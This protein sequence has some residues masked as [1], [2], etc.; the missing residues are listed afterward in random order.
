MLSQ[1]VLFFIL[2][3]LSPSP[4]NQR[5]RIF[6]TFA[7]IKHITKKAVFPLFR[8]HCF[9][10]CRLFLW[11]FYFFAAVVI[12]LFRGLAARQIRNASV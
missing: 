1:S 11:A 10:I 4:E 7:Y 5:I 12:F 6:S 8:K 2:K 3:A 9:F